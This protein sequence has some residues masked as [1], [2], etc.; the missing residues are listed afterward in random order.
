MENSLASLFRAIAVI[1]GF[2]LLIIV[3]ELG[4]FIAAKLSKV[5]VTDFFV[6]FGPKIFSFK[7]GET[8]YGL[9]SIPLG[10]YVKMSGSDIFENE[11]LEEDERSLA[12]ASLPKKLFII[13]SGSATNLI[14]A[15]IIIALTFQ[16]WGAATNVVRTTIKGTPARGVLRSGDK[17]IAVNGKKTN[18]WASLA[19]EIRNNP[20]R[21]IE[22]TVLREGLKKQLVVKATTKNRKGFIGIAPKVRRLGA[23]EAFKDSGIFIYEV[24][25]AINGLIFKAISGQPAQLARSSASIVGAVYMGAKVSTTILNYLFFIGSIS[26]VLGYV[27]LLPI[28]P[29]DAGRV[30]LYIFEKL[31]GRPIKKSTVIA[32]NAIGFAFL[33]TL[34]LY[35]LVK[36]IIGFF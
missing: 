8:E 19:K 14:A 30:V 33:L 22:I 31:I 5:R 36:D 18:N 26:L 27:N 2:M 7:K 21:N 28:P 9:A 20:K 11:E 3:H 17:I 10:G 23:L 1:G 15:L 16:F 25:K 24:V 4:H 29:L 6:G 32:I 35:L 12:K 13:F 34:M